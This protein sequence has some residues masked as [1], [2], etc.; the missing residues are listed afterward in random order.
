MKKYILITTL[1]T[2]LSSCSATFMADHGHDTYSV[3]RMSV[4]PPQP[5]RTRKTLKETNEYLNSIDQNSTYGQLAIMSGK[6]LYL[7]LIH[8]SEP[9]RPY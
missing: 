3:E 4:S 5:K 9:T 6:H 2:V 7:S 8:I 1:I